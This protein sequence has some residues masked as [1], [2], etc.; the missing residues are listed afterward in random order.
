MKQVKKM[1]KKGFNLI[2][3][4][5]ILATSFIPYIYVDAADSNLNGIYGIVYFRTKGCN[6]NTNYTVAGSNRS[7]YTN[8]CYG[9][10]AAFLG[11]NSNKT[12]VK[13]KL[14]GVTG[15]VNA[16][17]VQVI[18]YMAKFDT[19]YTS[20]Y[21]VKNGVLKHNVMSDIYRYTDGDSVSLGPKPSFMKEGASYWSYDGHYFYPATKDGYKKM[22]DDYVNN[23]TSNA[24]N[25]GNPYYNYYQY[26][27][28]RTQSNYTNTDIANYLKQI[29]IN[30]P[31]TSYPAGKGQ[32]LL[33]GEQTSFVQY[34]NEFGA[35]VGLVLGLARNE[36]ASGTSN[37]AFHAKNLFGHSAFDSSPGASAT[38]YLSVAQSIYAHDK[39]YISEG[40]L[41]PC[42]Q[43]NLYGGSYNYSKCHRGRYYG[44]HVGDKNSGMNVKYA[45]D[46]YWGDKA[47]Q[48]YYLLDSALGM[49][50]YNKYTIAVKTNGNSVPIYKEATTTSTKLYETGLVS[51]YP[52]VVLA[53]VTGQSINGNNKW[54]KIQTDPVLDSGRN[55]IIQDSG[56]YQ[57]SNN[58]AYVH[59]SNFRKINTGK[60]VKQNHL[61]T[62]DPAGGM[63]S[64]GT[65]QKKVLSVEQNVI[66]AVNAPTKKGDTFLGWTP[67]IMG[68]SGNVTYVAQ[69][70]NS[71]VKYDITFNPNG[72]K[73]TDGSTSNKVVTV[74]AGEIPSMSAPIKDGYTFK[75]WTPEI[76]AAT[77]NT[78]YTAVWEKNKVYY[79]VAFDAN[80]GQFSDG[81]TIIT[82]KVEEGVK[83]TLPEEPTRDGYIFKGWNPA[84]TE[85]EK[86]T[87][88]LAIWEKEKEVYNI[89]FDAN[90]G[91]FEDGKTTQVVKTIEG[92]LP[93][94]PKAPTRKGYKFTGWQ[95]NLE[96][97][98]KNTTY[99]AT[100]EKV[101]TYE[102]TFDADGGKFANNEEKVVIN[103]E[104]NTKPSITEPTKEGYLFQ[105]WEPAIK[106][107][108]ENTTYKA[109]WKEGTIEDILTKKD[110]EFYLDY[111]KEVNGKLE[112]KGYH[113][114]KGIDNDLKTKFTY[115]LVLKKQNTGKE[116]SQE[117]ER[118]TDEKEMTFPIYSGDGK[119]YKYAW[120]K[121]TISFDQLPQGDYTLYLR[122]STNQYYSKSYVQNMLLNEQDT[123]FQDK[124]KSVT[125]MNNYMDKNI[126]IEF[127]IRDK[128]IGK[129]ET[130][131]DVNQYS[132]VNDLE[133]VNNKLHIVSA[134]YSV[135]VDMRKQTTLNRNLIFENIDT[136]ERKIYNVGSLVT[137]VYPINLINADK[138]G[139]AKDRAWFDKTI[140]ISDL[141][142]GTYAIYVTNQSNISD[143]GELYD[144]LFADL[145][146][147][148]AT[149]NGKQFI[150]QL[151]ESKRNRIELVVK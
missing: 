20:N 16:S 4:F 12:K 2:L 105:G 58:Y 113:T 45:S 24:I 40:Y 39:F 136:F 131:Y 148:K 101:K 78:T 72:G 125:I 143:Y 135:G 115:E 23:R 83:P 49:Q 19:L 82:S 120:F 60:T 53:E 128:A 84:V 11:Y 103:V 48:Y 98:T 36:S 95:P 27:T 140:D 50:D 138:F 111:L 6:T 130:A 25:N 73:F 29:G 145:S 107:A 17:D 69:W 112:I 118:L 110:G 132:I 65:T 3:C 54:Y 62:F 142:K 57:F 109:T 15:W 61:I 90:E 126:P 121:S 147:A 146:N 137:P 70:K 99:T 92:E 79:D 123:E 151:N 91:T 119:N 117:L 42:D 106:E 67:T 85:I 116:Y 30:A 102:I 41:D 64:D 139:K 8:G 77:K 34:Q 35:N 80:G 127:I 56:Y 88:Y 22:I 5:F 63:F 122:T 38:S 89:T 133:F 18:D 7:G 144:V 134:T 94:A 37:I 68:A 1:L 21:T 52:V 59:S 76:T 26:L 32:S 129:K 66:P 87:N 96:K 13:F 71:V 9:A 10:D 43:T 141:E 150:F 93:E 75:G 33:Y 74:K 14:A 46:P 81:K 149:I 108:T 51:D 31:M 100:W 44:G 104:E 28:H 47:A 86:N 124:S 55:K 114:I 97:A